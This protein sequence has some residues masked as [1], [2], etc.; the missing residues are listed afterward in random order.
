MFCLSLGVKDIDN[1]ISLIS[2]YEI[3]E[4][5]LDLTNFSKSDIS[6]LCNKHGNLIFTFRADKIHTDQQRLTRLMTAIDEGASYIDVDI[7]NEPSF[8]ETISEKI[9]LQE[10]VG[11][12]TSY[13]NFKNTPVNSVLY[14]KIILMTQYN[15]ELMKITCLSHGHRDNSR[16]LLFNQAFKNMVSFTMGDKGSITRL[17]CLDYGAPFTYVCT[18]SEK[19]APGQLTKSD[20]LNLVNNNEIPA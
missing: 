1:A 10:S 20:I 12:I 3:A 6:R 7:D 4:I 11:L 18:E 8:L 9:S 2:E 5:R 13:H 17:L 16:I 15:P 19:T 14:D